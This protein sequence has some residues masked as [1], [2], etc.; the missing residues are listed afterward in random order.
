LPICVESAAASGWCINRERLD[1]V[2]QDRSSGIDS[3]LEHGLSERR[4]VIV[5]PQLACVPFHPFDQD[6][7]RVGSWREHSSEF[8]MAVNL[9]HAP[10]TTSQY[11]YA[12][13]RRSLPMQLALYTLGPASWTPLAATSQP[14]P[15][16]LRV[17][18]NARETCQPPIVRVLTS[19]SR[20]H[21][22]SEER[23][24]DAHCLQ[25]EAHL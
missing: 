9:I 23:H 6:L 11:V 2:D 20:H 22:G 10:K 7:Q 24:A 4:P 14:M 1:P 21:D 15:G 25:P 19:S 8:H 13:S 18:C 12:G 16:F 17:V 3:C 5:V